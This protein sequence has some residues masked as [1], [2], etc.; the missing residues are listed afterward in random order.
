[1]SLSAEAAVVSHSD[2]PTP[3]SKKLDENPTTTSSSATEAASTGRDGAPRRLDFGFLPIPKRCQFDDTF[4]FSTTL[5]ILLS[6]TSMLTVANIYYPQP[7]LVQ[8]SIRYDVDYDRST[9][10]TSLLQAGYLCGLVFI[11]PLGD[12]VRRRPLLLLL[13][14]ATAALSLGQAAAPNFA[15]FEALAFIQGF[16][17]VTPQILNPLTADLA[18]AHRRATAVSITVSGLISGMVFGRLFAGILTRF[19]S[20]P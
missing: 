13:V 3:G 1:M 18:P 9:R 8:L 15:S 11:T 19:T 2:P 10:V 7:I 12:L 5:N 4:K 14:L 16:V 20:S 6:L 17:T